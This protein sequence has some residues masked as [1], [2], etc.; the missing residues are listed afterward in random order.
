MCLYPRLIKNRK[1][2]ANKKNGG[3]VPPV[4]DPRVIWVPVGC[5][6]CME[7]RK[8]KSREW[9]VR[10]LEEIKHDKRGQFIT[11]TFSNESIKEL[12]KVDTLSK[13]NGYTLDNELATLAMRRFLER[14]EKNTENH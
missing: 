5:G 11:L 10:L 14:W 1:Y 2:V 8:Q 3:N 9:K 7:C 6:R 4:K 12:C 13:L